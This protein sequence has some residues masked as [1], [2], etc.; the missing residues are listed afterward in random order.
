MATTIFKQNKMEKKCEVCEEMNKRII[1]Y[2]KETPLCLKHYTQMIRYNKIFERTRYDP[3]KI[4]KVE[5]HYEMELY[6]NYGN[7]KETTIFN[8]HIKKIK[9]HKWCLDGN[10]YI[11]T[12]FNKDNLFLQH[13]ILPKKKNYRVDHINQ[14]P[15]DNRKENL[16]YLTVG[17]NLHNSKKAKGVS[18]CNTF[19]KWGTYINKDNKRIRL[20]YHKTE[21]EALQVRKEAEKKYYPGIKYDN[22]GM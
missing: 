16:R 14:N 19:N 1:Y 13:L 10:N 3:N 7:T 2:K 5:D 18:Y 15:L 21:E 6:D 20:G 17:E 12:R 4:T 9:R 8:S 11:K 22:K